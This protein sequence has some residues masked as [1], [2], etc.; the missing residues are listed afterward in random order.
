VRHRPLLYIETSVFGFYFDPEPRNALRREAVR[1]LFRQIDLGMLEAA[2]SPVTS[3][4]LIAAAEPLRT[5]V[6]SLLATIAPL[7]A[8]ETE[9]TRLAEVYIKE[10]VIPPAEGLDARHA[11]YA[12]VGRAEV[13]VS[14]NL[15]HLANEWTA[16]GLNAVNMREGYPL[17]S[18]RT[19][20][21]VVLNES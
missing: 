17:V 7:R 18:I 12:T 2:T 14:L 9:V 1:E 21:Q 8:D 16:R 5:Q 6:L 10:G 4:E 19:P 13:I 11:A 3:A 15:R 20:E